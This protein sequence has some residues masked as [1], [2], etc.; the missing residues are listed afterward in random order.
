MGDPRR[1]RKKFSKP[2]HPWQKQRLEEEAAHIKG[3]GL[4]NKKEVWKAKAKLRHF[5]NLAKKLVRESDKESIKESEQ[6]VQKLYKMGLLSEN[7]TIN[8]IL[9]LS[10]KDIFERRLQTVVVRKGLA[11]TL[12]QARQFITHGHITVNEKSM[13]VP[14]Y[15]V[16][17]DEDVGFADRSSLKSE[18]HPERTVEIKEE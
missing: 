6:L 12:K 13:R 1:H 2:S 7:G 15:L 17:I 11:K 9:S 16:R 18:E 10:E 4:K 3:Y 14:S 5:A 8:D